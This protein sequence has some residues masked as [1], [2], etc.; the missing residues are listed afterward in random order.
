MM[1]GKRSSDEAFKNRTYVRLIHPN[2]RRFLMKKL[3]SFALYALATPFITLGA[4]S[5]MAQQSAE[6]DIYRS[7]QTAP[8]D[9]SVTPSTPMAPQGS[10]GTPHDKDAMKP[11]PVT[12]QGAQETPRAVQSGS[13]SAVDLKKTTGAIMQN[14]G[15]MSSIPSGGMQANNLIGA[16]VKTSGD[17]DV[18]PVSDLIINEDGHIVAIVVSVGGFLGMGER[19]VAIGWDD[20]TRSA[21]SDDVELQINATRDQLLAAPEYKKLKKL[22]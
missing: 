2:Q 21:T 17:V 14:R 11:A 1:P 4:G 10:P 19:E 22:D 12:S 20:V 7:Q 9:Q 3:H 8:R 16:E 13:P 15:Y 6:Q 5:V 18:G